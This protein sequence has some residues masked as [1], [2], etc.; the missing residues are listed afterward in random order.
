MLLKAIR[1]CLTQ[2][3]KLWPRPEALQEAIASPP[4]TVSPM[5][6]KELSQNLTALQSLVDEEERRKSHPQ[7]QPP[8][9][10]TS[11]KVEEP[12]LKY[13]Q[14]SGI[15][16]IG[17]RFICVGYSGKGEGLNNVEWENRLPDDDPANDGPIPRGIW[18]I[19]PIGNSGKFVMRMVLS[20]VTY[21]GTR[22]AFLIHGPH[23]DDNKDSSSGCIILERKYR[24]EIAASGI[25]ILKVV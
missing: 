7:F 10:L 25:K 8:T 23:A 11:T 14:K 18:K 1:W 2:F 19:G 13:E 20:P 16:S 21:K 12:Y 6:L 5:N 22:S 3:L 4:T 17:G 24:D 9:P 15:T